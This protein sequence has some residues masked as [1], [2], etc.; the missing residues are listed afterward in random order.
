MGGLGGLEVSGGWGA[1]GGSVRAG[2]SRRRGTRGLEELL[3]PG[4][5]GRGGLPGPRG[6]GE[7]SV[8][9]CG[10]SVGCPRV[11]W[12]V[13]AG[14]VRREEPGGVAGD[15]QVRAVGGRRLHLHPPHAA[16][17][18][19]GRAGENQPGPGAGHGGHGGGGHGQRVPVVWGEWSRSPCPVPSAGQNQP[20][21]GVGTGRDMG[22]TGGTSRAR[23]GQGMAS[24]SPWSGEGGP[25]SRAQ[26]QCWAEPARTW[27]RAREGGGWPAG[28]R[29][30][31]M[32]VPVPP[33][34]CSAPGG[35]C[36]GSRM[37]RGSRVGDTGN[38]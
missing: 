24:A 35:R 34:P 33:T 18:A 5:G 36:W 15:N 38:P 6:S 10:V 25:R 22:G 4:D 12:G 28:P 23:G 26:F 8:G 32:G 9:T 30:L 31:G 3:V 2:G 21:P 37:S 29:G 13:P 7:A 16:G 1:C 17:E 11:R 27:H 19:G 20:G 14:L